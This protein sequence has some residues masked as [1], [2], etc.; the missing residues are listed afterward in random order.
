MPSCQETR[1][2]ARA[3]RTEPFGATKPPHAR[4]DWDCRIKNASADTRMVSRFS[5]IGSSCWVYLDYSP[6]MTM[7]AGEKFPG[8]FPFFQESSQ[9]QATLQLFHIIFIR[10]A[11][12]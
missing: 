9:D 7:G 11:G 1:V 10:N 8:C 12:A 4:A 6:T 2:A 5:I 3:S